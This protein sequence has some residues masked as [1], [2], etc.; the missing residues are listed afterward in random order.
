MST[1]KSIHARV[2]AAQESPDAIPLTLRP[3]DVVHVRQAHPD[4]TGYVWVED[5]Q[6]SAGWVPM[7]LIDTHSGR[8]KAK[9]E[10]CSAE[11]SVQPGDSVRLI[12]ED[13][14]H[15]ACWCEDRHSERGWVRNECLQFE[16][17][18]G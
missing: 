12:W 10:Y 7:D 17:A 2:V 3:G 15:G 5:G 16:E 6:L 8:T 11:L 18:E 9:A 1:L 13:P 4:R 14:A